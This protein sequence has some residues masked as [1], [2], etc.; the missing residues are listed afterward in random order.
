MNEDSGTL[1]EG[2]LYRRE[3]LPS[4]VVEPTEQSEL[5]SGELRWPP[6]CVNVQEEQDDSCSDNSVGSVDRGRHEDTQM[7]E[8]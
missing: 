4:I 8:G 6:R 3:R 1:P 5:E 2:F 7:N